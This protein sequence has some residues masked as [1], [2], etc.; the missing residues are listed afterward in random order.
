[1]SEL[2]TPSQNLFSPHSNQLNPEGHLIF[3]NIKDLISRKNYPCVAAVKAL[4]Q[5]EYSVGIYKNFGSAESWQ[6]I[7]QDLRFFIQEQQKTKSTY[8][9]FWAVFEGETQFTEDEYET[10]MWKELSHLSSF[11]DKNHDWP[12]EEISNPEN[13]GFCLSIDKKPFFVV[14]VHPNSSRDA[15]KF[16]KPALIFNVFEQFQNL[17]KAGLYESMKAIIRKR[18]VLFQ[19]SVN[20][21]VE[22]YGDDW[23]SIQF[24]G[25]E[26]PKSWKC[27]FHFLFQNE[28]R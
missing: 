19:G 24:S 7:R 14:G 23:E 26:N 15:R 9:T 16:F 27:P 5:K 25:K 6:E 3:K 2:L 4:H 21:M 17:Q 12:T 11:E 28:K 18:D 10:L 22:K 13:P 1:M 20:P 8:L